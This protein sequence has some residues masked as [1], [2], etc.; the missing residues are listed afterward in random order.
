[1]VKLKASVSKWD[2]VGIVEPEPSLLLFNKLLIFPEVARL[3]A[4]NSPLTS[5][6]T[7][8]TF[9]L[10]LSLVPRGTSLLQE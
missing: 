2:I 4:W 7:S 10:V 3:D 8:F 1:M 5:F 6:I 9:P